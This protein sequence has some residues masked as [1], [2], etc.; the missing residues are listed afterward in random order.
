MT[1]G[2]LILRV[3]RLACRLAPRHWEFDRDAGGEIAAHWRDRTKINPS[4]YDGRV[5]LASRVETRVDA[6]NLTVLEVDFFE[7]RFSRFLAWRDFGFPDREVYNCFSMPALRSIDGG[8]LLGEMGAGHSS[9][10]QLY[11]PCGTPD[12]SDIVGETV[13][14]GGSIVRE[15]AEETG[16]SITRRMFAPDWRIVFDGQRVACVNIVDW[17]EPAHLLLARVERHI[18]AEEKP[19]LA[20]A[21]VVLRREELADRRIPGFMAAFLERELRA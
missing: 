19:E 21:R 6:D 16:V 12:L 14:L 18:A 11:F 17:P 15:L 1:E 3:D 9:A 5:L 8:F 10:G 2:A 7:T 13:D 4:L 20:G